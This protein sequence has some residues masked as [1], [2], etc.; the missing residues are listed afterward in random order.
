MR[1][2]G[3]ALV[4]TG[5]PGLVLF[6]L[7][8][9]TAFAQQGAPPP[10]VDPTHGALNWII[11][12]WYM[13]VTCEREDGTQVQIQDAVVLRPAIEDPAGRSL[14]ATFFGLDVADAKRCF[15]MINSNVLD[16]RGVLYLTYTSQRRTD[17]GLK[18]LRDALEDGE[19]TYQI[20]RGKLRERDI[21]SGEAPRMLDY[22]SKDGRFIVTQLKRGSD[23]YKLL[24]TA[25]PAQ[26]QTGGAVRWLSLELTARTMDPVKTYILEDAERRPGR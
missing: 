11:G 13:P 9:G 7:L 14:K 3:H 8:A 16:R 5:A 21:A 19:L 4:R 18:D 1:R 23:G 24:S 25:A 6:A 20:T 12:R 2:R 17:L 22:T 10:H 15:T 26:P